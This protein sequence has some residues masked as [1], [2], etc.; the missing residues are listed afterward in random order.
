MV[1]MEKGMCGSAE[2]WGGRGSMAGLRAPVPD[3]GG[4]AKQPKE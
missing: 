2:G 1:E 4:P 3:L